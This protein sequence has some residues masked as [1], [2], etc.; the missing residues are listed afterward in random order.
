MGMCLSLKATS[1]EEYNDLKSQTQMLWISVQ[2]FKN[3]RK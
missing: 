1:L 3:K 2:N